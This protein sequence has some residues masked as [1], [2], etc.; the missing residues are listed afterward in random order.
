MTHPIF[1]KDDITAFDF[2]KPG[3]QKMRNTPLGKIYVDMDNGDIH[4]VQRW[5]YKFLQDEIWHPHHQKASP[6][7]DDE[8]YSFHQA[9][10]ALIWKF[11]NSAPMV[12][13]GPSPELINISNL[14]NANSPHL[15]VSVTGHSPFAT[16]FAGKDLFID[17]DAITC[18]SH[19]HYHVS[20]RKML[21]GRAFRSNVTGQT[22]NLAMID[23]KRD[24]ASQD[25]LHPAVTD[26]FYT[27]P[28]EFGHAIGYGTDEYTAYAAKRSDVTSIMNIG[29][30]IRPRHFNFIV[31]QL[32]A[33]FPHTVFRI[34]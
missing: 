17:F 20:V 32:N 27:V 2:V 19:P 6:W 25:G 33:M 29:K 30:E 1:L 31:G 13:A 5:K 4:F 21:P 7:T 14:M 28:H 26:D 8:E 22:I 23:V 18:V 10:V 15:K 11:W 24:R 34:A 3:A 12:N 16:K 9:A